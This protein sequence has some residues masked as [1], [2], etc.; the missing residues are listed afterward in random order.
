MHKANPLLACI[1]TLC[2][3]VLFVCPVVEASNAG[4]SFEADIKP[5]LTL[6]CIKCHNADTTKAD[7]RIDTLQANF[8]GAEV[9]TWH[10]ILNRVEV[11][12]MPPQDADGLPTP[13]RRKLVK[14]IRN[15][16]SAIQRNKLEGDRTVVRRLTKYEYNNTL[17]DLTGIELDYA[18]DLPPDSMSPNGFKNNGASL[19]LSAIQMEYYVLAARRAMAKAIVTGPAPKVY[20]NRFD[21]SSPSN[22]PKVKTEVGNR[23]QPGSRFFGKM[24]EFPR[25]G[26]F[27]IRIK[28]SSLV[29]AGQGVPRMQVAIGLRSDTVSP[30]KMLAEIDVA[31]PESSPEVYEFRGRM[32]EFPLPGHNPKFPGVTIAVTNIYDDGLPAVL[33]LQYQVI[34]FG[35]DDSNQIE[36][37][38]KENSLGLHTSAIFS[39]TSKLVRDFS[40]SAQTLQKT[41]EE[42]RLLK[43]NSDAPIDI[44]FRLHDYETQRKKLDGLLQRLS[45]ESELDHRGMVASFEKS[46]DD[47]LNDHEEVLSKFKHLSPLNRKDRDAIRALLPPPPE[48]TTLVLE[49]LEFEGP[50]YEKWPPASHQVL[51]P[52]LPSSEL[53]NTERTRASHAIKTFMKRAFR[54]PIGESDVNYILSFYDEVRPKSESFEEAMREA[55]VMILVSPEFLYHFTPNRSLNSRPLSQHELATRISY[56]LWS[57][58]PDKALASLADSGELS[59]TPILESQIRRMLKSPKSNE[60]INHFTD[61]WLDLAGIERVAINPE[62]YPSFNDALKKSMRGET[63]AFFGELLRKDLSALNLLDS[64]FL[65]LDAAMAKHY[66]LKGPIGGGFERIELPTDSKRG[67]L[68]TQASVLLLNSTGEDSHPIRRGVWLRSRLLDDA[69]APPPPDVPELDSEDSGFATLPVRQQLEQHRTREACNDCHRGIDPW[70]IPFENFDATGVWRAEALRIV[71]KKR[72]NKLRVPVSSS[73]VLPNGVAIE[74]IHGLKTHLLQNERR[75]FAKALVSRLLEYSTGQTVEFSDRDLIEKLTNQFEDAK[76]RLSDLIVAIVQCEKFQNK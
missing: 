13:Q 58:T 37:R 71:Q 67:G 63:R 30:T 17:R 27:V 51:L 53:R 26:T 46:N 6:F 70:G 68:L 48:R 24:L 18:V 65:M 72:K 22:T 20:R 23:M 38:A 4:H 62:Y 43:S 29:P 36:T 47:T 74:D 34:K 75:R 5:I 56:F 11:G 31:N 69:P 15:E 54:R 32:E 42:L 60:F 35:H 55:F 19:G 66:G 40:K 10:D 25:E 45:K 12:D 14:W 59:A 9:E 16:L 7:L 3:S 21:T 73:S 57:T 52:P 50:V 28:A 1:L 61:Q 2:C 39:S 41:I 64:D 76:Y 8:S 33:P 44:A 49:S